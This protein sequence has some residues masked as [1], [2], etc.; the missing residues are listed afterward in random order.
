MTDSPRSSR[1]SRPGPSLADLETELLAKLAQVRAAITGEV[2]DAAGV[3]AARAALMRVFDH[4]LLHQG[5]PEGAANLELIAEG[6]WIEPVVS[7]EAVEGYDER[8]SPVLTS[9]RLEEVEAGPAGIGR[10]GSSHAEN[11][12]RQ[13][14]VRQLFGPIPIVRSH[15]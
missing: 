14:L 12:L 3:D 6:Y 9:K 1:R 11:N 7:D 5:R 13:S 8:L 10:E 2:T 4:F 15:D